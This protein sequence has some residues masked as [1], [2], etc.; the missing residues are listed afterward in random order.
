MTRTLLLAFALALAASVVAQDQPSSP[1]TPGTLTRLAHSAPNGNEL[2]FLL[3]DGSVLVQGF[4]DSDWYKLTPDVNGS[5]LN[6]TW[7]RM[8]NLPQGYSPYAMA[9][10]VLADGRVVISG[11]E[12]NFGNFA[13]TNLG[14]IYDPVANTWTSI[15]H[16][17][18]WDFIGDS[19]SVV[20][21]GGKFLVGRKFDMQMAQLDPKTLTWTAV[22]SDGKSDWFSEEGWTLMPNGTILTVDVL[23]NPNSEHYVPSEGR[24]V[25]D[26]STITNLQGPPELGCITGDWGE[27]CPPGE[28]GPAILRPDGSVFATG[29]RHQGASTG[30]TAI[31]H[32]GQTPD[33]VGTWTPG[34]DFPN[35]DDAGDNFAV[36]LTN[37]NVLVEGSSGR[38]YEFD[39]TNFNAGVASSGG[40]LIVLPT[41]EVLVGGSFIYTPA[42]Q[43]YNPAWAPHLY[44]ANGTILKRGQ[45][46]AIPGQRF[47]GMSQAAAFGDEFET[48]TNYPLIRFTFTATHHVVYVRTHD[49]S[50]MGVQTGNNLTGTHVD[51][52]ANMESGIAYMELVA[53]G[54]PSPKLQ[55]FIF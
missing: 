33:D 17:A 16:P 31:Y 48:A 42:N 5:Y 10:A 47:N 25:Q 24:W 43:N 22:S 21:P 14:A 38:L 7:T 30:H 8:A 50:T 13:F 18:G 3:T 19:Q 46:Y 34:P 1:A 51:L 11:G 2:P 45:T 44:M 52:P 35:G 37:G 26:G 49:H 32:P 54:I 55:V 41:G 15:G 9:S 20:L 29:A 28:I 27:Y 6:G 4:G 23:N 39:G 36:L 40:P 12:Y 53:N